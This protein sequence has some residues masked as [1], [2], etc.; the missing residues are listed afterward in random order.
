LFLKCTSTTNHVTFHT[1][2]AV[3]HA[4]NNANQLVDHEFKQKPAKGIC[5]A[6]Q[7][8]TKTMCPIDAGK[9]RVDIHGLQSIQRNQI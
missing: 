1:T 2:G 9:A 6:R 7:D 5:Y 4:T 8:W 3:D